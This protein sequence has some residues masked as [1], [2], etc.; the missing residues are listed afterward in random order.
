MAR[1]LAS[2]NLYA[3][4]CC[5]DGRYCCFYIWIRFLSLRRRKWR[6]DQI[7]LHYCETEV[8]WELMAHPAY[9]PRVFLV[10][11]TLVSSTE[12]AFMYARPRRTGN[13]GIQLPRTASDR[14]LNFCSW[15]ASEALNAHSGPRWS[16]W[17]T[18]DCDLFTVMLTL[19]EKVWKSVKDFRINLMKLMSG[20]VI[21]TSL[22][23]F[24]HLLR[25]CSQSDRGCR[26][27]RRDIVRW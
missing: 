11:L 8:G 25:D 13:W 15:W 27:A 17:L 14:V 12:T 6:N 19:L 1:A 18:V 7:E 22:M 20:I 4:C 9:C 10:W 26:C 23:L 24:H 21:S 3:C 5:K 16:H 2:P